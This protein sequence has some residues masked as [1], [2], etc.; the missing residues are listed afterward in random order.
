MRNTLFGSLIALMLLSACEQQDAEAP[1]VAPPVKP[2]S[3]LIRNVTVI[4][5]SGAP[6]YPA[7][8]RISGATMLA[9]GQTGYRP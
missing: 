6:G 7:A 2:A 1:A 8:V 3:W 5:A 4:D 9:A